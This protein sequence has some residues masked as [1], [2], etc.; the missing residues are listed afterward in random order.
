VS[1]PT[2]LELMPPS[3]TTASCDLF[4]LTILHGES[5]AVAHRNRPT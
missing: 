1:L 5:V 2:A 4:L 3:S